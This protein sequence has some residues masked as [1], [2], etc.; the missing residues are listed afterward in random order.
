MQTI[1]ENISNSIRNKNLTLT[2]DRYSR[3]EEIFTVLERNYY[4]QENIDEEAMIRAAIKSLVGAIDDPYTVYLDN[5]EYANFQRDLRGSSDLEGIGAV[6]AK[7][8]YYI[9]IEEIIKESPAFQA[10][11][12]PLDRILAVDGESTQNETVGEAVMRI[13]WP[14]GSQ[15]VLTI[16]RVNAIDDTKEI[17]DVT[18]TRDTISIPSVS[19]EVQTVDGKSIGIITISMIGEETE[20]LLKREI[21]TTTAQNIEW[22][23]VDLRGNGGGILPIAVQIASHFL[24]KDTLVTIARYQWYPE[25][26]FYSLG[27]NEFW[28]MPVVILIDHMTASAWEIIALALRE[29]IGATL[30]GTQTFGKWSIQTLHEFSDRDSLKYTIGRRYSPNNISIDQE[31]ILPDIV[32]EFNADMYIEQRFDN[33]LEEAKKVIKT[34]LRK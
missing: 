19:S 13:R 1:I 28:N 29:Q 21:V 16:E 14:K 17:F 25:E 30:I 12:R 15:V 23:I 3:F 5:Q 7:R 9:L 11:L 33:Q 31:G 4:Y 26:R 22:I 6:V 34:K 2:K 8:D 20:S 27:Y 24:P 10:G 18:V 32:I